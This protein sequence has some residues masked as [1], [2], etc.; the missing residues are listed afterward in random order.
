MKVE[1]AE[2]DPLAADWHCRGSAKGREPAVV[3]YWESEEAVREP[4]GAAV[5]V[6][7]DWNYCYYPVHRDCEYSRHWVFSDSNSRSDY[8]AAW[9]QAYSRSG[10]W[11][12]SSSTHL[13]CLGSWVRLAALAY[14][15][16]LWE[17]KAGMPS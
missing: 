8:S 2:E 1:W 10:C 6:L 4:A 9:A 17:W 15:P 13:G 5:A 3:P 14:F 11:V 7:P 12:L 16:Q